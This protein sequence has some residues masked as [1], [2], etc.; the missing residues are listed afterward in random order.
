M[1]DLIDGPVMSQGLLLPFLQG[2]DINP[3][4]KW[5]KSNKAM[6][7]ERILFRQRRYAYG[8]IRVHTCLIFITISGEAVLISDESSSGSK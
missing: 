6:G 4:E 8:F 2:R 7:G 3:A 1:P 5:T